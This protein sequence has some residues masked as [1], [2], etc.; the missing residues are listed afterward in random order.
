VGSAETTGWFNDW[1][2][3]YHLDGRFIVESVWLTEGQA[4]TVDITGSNEDPN[5]LVRFDEITLDLLDLTDPPTA[6][7]TNTPAPTPTKSTG[8]ST[9]EVYE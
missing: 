4:F 7:P 3:P 2:E 1:Q 5:C 6:T 8:V 9:F